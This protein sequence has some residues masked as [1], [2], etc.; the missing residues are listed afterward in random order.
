MRRRMCVVAMPAIILRLVI[1][2]IGANL[3]S[4]SEAGFTI[5][6]DEVSTSE[7]PISANQYSSLGVQ[8]LTDDGTIRAG[9]SQG[10]P[11]NWGLEGTN[12]PHFL[13]F[14]GSSYS[15]MAIF[16]GPIADFT[17]D[18]ARSN[19]STSGNQIRLEGYLAG[20]LVQSLT[21]S[22]GPIN[23]WTTLSLSANVD[24]VQVLG[25]GANFH[26]YGIDNMRWQSANLQAVPEP[27]TCAL[28]A[29]GGGTMCMSKRLRRRRLTENSRKCNDPPRLLG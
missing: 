13:G 7:S 17:V 16:D 18:A 23:S 1:C 20:A 25:L 11:G 6:F 12:G 26:P 3:A 14:N 15:M 28:L 8:L 2:S 29:L 9:I 19:G 22:F 5:S 27:S 4:F 24:T 21:V 10:D